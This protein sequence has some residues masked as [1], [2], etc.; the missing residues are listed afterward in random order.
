MNE[1][2]SKLVLDAAKAYIDFMEENHKGWSKAFFRFHINQGSDFGGT[3]SYIKNDNVG[4]LGSLRDK[5]IINQLI[6]LLN[7]LALELEKK[8]NNFLVCLLGAVAIWQ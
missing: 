1:E 5:D 4:L 6:N 3:G 8:G 2:S 7:Q